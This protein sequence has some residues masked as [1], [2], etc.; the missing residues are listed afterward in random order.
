MN[1]LLTRKI[2]EII[3]IY[4]RFF[5]KK[6]NVIAIGLGEKTI[7]NIGTSEPCL[8]IFVE[9]KIPL[10][11]LS[12][13]DLL[14][15]DFLG[16]K[17]DVVESGKI[18]SLSPSDTINNSN[19][20][21][22]NKFRTRLRPI[23]AGCDI[24]LYKDKNSATLGAIVFDNKTNNPY[25]LSNHHVLVNEDDP[26]KILSVVQP[27]VHYGG[28]SN[29]NIIAM[30]TRYVPI[31]TSAPNLVDC[32]A[33]KILAHVEYIKGIYKIGEISGTTDAEV[34]QIVRKVGA[35]TQYTV[36]KVTATN[37]SCQRF[38]KKGIKEYF[39]NQIA[40]TQ[41]SDFGDSGSVYVNAKNKV[42]GL[43]FAKSDLATFLNPISHVLKLLNV[44]F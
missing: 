29:F 19:N 41:M 23:E 12:K 20:F 8:K 24:S 22:N 38:S 7:K 21:V 5:L 32:A 9:K 34:K 43:G 6:E 15:K 37:V 35:E 13:N 40:V 28:S 4:D 10:N 1:C 26:K 33:S 2:L 18:H 39:T 11:E 16:V 27:S 14:P 31:K 17:I 3:Y 36:G 25:I 30:G 44:H 42:V